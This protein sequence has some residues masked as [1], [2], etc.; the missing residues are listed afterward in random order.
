MR[1]DLYLDIGSQIKSDVSAF[2]GAATGAVTGAAVRRVGEGHNYASGQLVVATGSTTGT[3]D[4]FS[5]AGKLQDSANGSTGW[6]DVPGTTITPVIVENGQAKVNFIA[7]GCQAYVR[8]VV[9]P[10]FTGGSSP[11]IPAVGILVLG[12]NSEAGGVV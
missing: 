3:P 5:V 4:S 2:N 11:A 6:N 9:T 1:P 7:R 10:T 8:A 12:G